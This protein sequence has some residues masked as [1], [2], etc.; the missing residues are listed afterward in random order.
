MLQDIEILR[1]GTFTASNGKDVSFT[2]DDLTRIA[3]NYTPEHHE[4]PVTIGHPVDNRPAY[5]WVKALKASGGKLMASL[6][7]TPEFMETVKQGL[8]KKRSA[9]IY[10]DL[11]GKGPYLRHVAFLG[12]MPPAVKAL[13]DIN[14]K[15]DGRE[16]LII[17]FT[18]E[19]RKMSWKDLFKKAVDEMPDPEKQV[20]IMP[21]PPEVSFSEDDVKRREEE[22]AKKAREEAALEF[23]EKARQLEAERDAS[24]HKA[25]ATARIDALVKD[26]KLLPA[27]V[28]G[29]LVELACTLSRADTSAIELSEGKKQPPY[30]VFMGFLEGLP[31]QIEFGEVAG[32]DKDTVQGGAGD[33][34]SALVAGKM[35]ETPRLTY[36]LAFSEV[37]ME[38]PELAH[39]YMTEISG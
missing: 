13:S 10:P 4:A 7:L 2:D 25:D 15:D 3:S 28:K 33:K 8:F 37:Q 39:E 36:A 19:E 18:E 12:A 35:K 29:G 26:G 31:K 27:W 9:S 16:H 21:P 14:L 30:D 34:L 20:V 1:T 38:H 24:L 5:G 23:A 6:D 32:K 22:A 17:D 11:D